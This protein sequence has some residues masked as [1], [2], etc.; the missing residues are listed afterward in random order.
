MAHVYVFYPLTMH[1]M[2]LTFIT[3]ATISGCKSETYTPQTMQNNITGTSAQKREVQSL[4]YVGRLP[5]SGRVI[6]S[7]ENGT[8]I[9]EGGL[10]GLPVEDEA[11]LS[12]LGPMLFPNR[13][14]IGNSG[15]WINSSGEEWRGDSIRW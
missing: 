8:L 10:R 2:F 6:W 12:T 9:V 1:S 3:L 7:D 4:K 13:G 5:K 14:S 11:Y 15:I